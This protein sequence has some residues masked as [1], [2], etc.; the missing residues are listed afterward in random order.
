MDCADEELRHVIEISHSTLAVYRQNALPAEVDLRDI[1]HGSLE[2][3]R[4]RALERGIRLTTHADGL[5]AI[6]ATVEAYGGEVRQVVINLVRNA[7]EA[8]ASGGEVRIFIQ[9]AV[10]EGL[11]SDGY[12]LIVEDDGCGIA[13]DF[14][15]MLF[16]PSTST[17]PNGTG[18]G[19]WIVRQIIEKHGGTIRVESQTIA[20]TGSRFIVW[21]PRLFASGTLE[22]QMR[23][24]QAVAS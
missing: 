19:L 9:A 24:A 3:L 21:M 14:L 22:T 2:L 8:S 23:G 10:D 12:H 20:P 11:G 18:I 6:K 13:S 5:T 16:R 4:T 17:K 1:V 15:P 7:I